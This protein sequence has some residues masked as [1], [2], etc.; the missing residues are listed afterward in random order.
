MYEISL[1]PRR[2]PAVKRFQLFAAAFAGSL[3]SG[4]FLPLAA[5]HTFTDSRSFFRFRLSIASTCS[6]YFRLAGKGQQ[7]SAAMK[8]R[9]TTLLFAL[10]LVGAFVALI[11]IF[12]LQRRGDDAAQRNLSSPRVLSGGGATLFSVAPRAEPATGMPVARHHQTRVA[13]GATE[14]GCRALS[15]LLPASPFAKGDDGSVDTR[16]ALDRHV[17]AHCTRRI[18]HFDAQAVVRCLATEDFS[19]ASADADVPTFQF[20]L[21]RGLAAV[22]D[23]DSPTTVEIVDIPPIASAAANASAPWTA[24]FFHGC[25]HGASDFCPADPDRCPGC[26]GL[27]EERRYVSAALRRGMRVVALSSQSRTG[28]RCWLRHSFCKRGSEGSAARS[29]GALNSSSDGGGNNSTRVRCVVNNADVL[30]VVAALKSIGADT[31]PLVVMGASSGGA[32]VAALPTLA[33]HILPRLR[34]VIA[35]VSA[36]APLFAAGPRAAAKQ[37]PDPRGRGRNGRPGAKRTPNDGIVRVYSVMERDKAT[38]RRAESIVANL[39][40]NAA[41]LSLLRPLPLSPAFFSDR[42][43][44][45]SEAVSADIFARLDAGGFLSKETGLLHEN[46]RSSRWRGA[47]RDAVRST[48]DSL[49]ADQSPVAEELNVAFSFHEFSADDAEET[50]DFIAANTRT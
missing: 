36:T 29:A 17:R 11:P 5:E 42:I 13:K 49:T 23:G 44:N 26:R 24:V 31:A 21:S 2:A 35:Q 3:F 22:S 38:V 19:S 10:A 30:A 46:P 4:L 41:K 7:R 45:F 28:S 43:D 20:E 27:P 14:H 8:V 40:R 34:A 33:P 25:G 47:I 12:T 39:P 37:G 1:R 18:L 32:F 50:L 6:V 15:A 48:G 16:A 9:P